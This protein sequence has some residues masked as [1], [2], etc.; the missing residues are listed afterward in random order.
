MREAPKTEG[1]E[2]RLG[3]HAPN[4]HLERMRQ[5]LHCQEKHMA[6]FMA[7]PSKAWPTA[8]PSLKF[9]SVHASEILRGERDAFQLALDNQRSDT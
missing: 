7:G 5:Q 1:P 8:L 3:C 9:T 6:V 2:H 4:M